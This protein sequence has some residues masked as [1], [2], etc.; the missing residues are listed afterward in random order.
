MSARPRA[1]TALL[2]V[3]LAISARASPA[4]PRPPETVRL[5]VTRDAR[6]ARCPDAS[7]MRALLRER[8]RR[9]AVRD[10]AA[11]SAS[12]RF[13]RER[14]RYAATLR[15]RRPG[16]PTTL[17]QLRSAGDDCARL[18]DAASLVLA[19]AIDPIGAL[20]PAVQAPPAAVQ[21][22]PPVAQALPPVAQATP[23]VVQAT[24]AIVQAA[25]PVAQALS[26]A[27]RALPPAA[28]PTPTLQFAALAT[29]STGVAPGL[30]GGAFRPGLALRATPLFGATALPIELAIDAPGSLDDVARGARVDALPIQL[31][32]GVCRRF[33]RRV[34]V[35]LCAVAAATA[36]VAWGDGYAPD[37]AAVGFALGVGARAGVE[38][39]LA[40]RWCFVA[41]AELRALALRPALQVNG[42]AGGALWTAPPVAATLAFGVAWSNR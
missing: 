28:R 21:A 16:L 26:P 17:R 23:A 6:S 9:D 12:L 25:P 38:L 4:Q 40:G 22:L 5:D 24:P 41:S 18:A 32:A 37:R 36:I 42:T 14:A 11:T 1:P 34:V 20:H 35:P 13:T 3:A 10:D 29:L 33:G 2:S 15:L 27:A 31:G 30:L 7:A 19:L 8:L 39:P